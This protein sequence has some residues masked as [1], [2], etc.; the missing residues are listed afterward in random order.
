MKRPETASLIDRCDGLGQ[1]IERFLEERKQ[2]TGASPE[3]SA[4]NERRL[5]TRARAHE[6]RAMW[7]TKLSFKALA[8]LRDLRDAGLDERLV[9]ES[10]P[11]PD[12]HSAERWQ[13]ASEAR[14]FLRTG[15]VD[16]LGM[17]HLAR[18]FRLVADRLR[19]QG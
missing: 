8:M 15:W 13:A 1:E 2:V 9:P 11:H 6:T 16:E 19:E 12:A 4:R 10:G 17:A 3:R 7:A 14:D 5:E 18:Y